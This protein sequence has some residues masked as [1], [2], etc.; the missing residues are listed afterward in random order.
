MFGQRKLAAMVLL[1]GACTRISAS[2]P[3]ALA[4]RGGTSSSGAAGDSQLGGAA[5]APE[6]RGG[7]AGESSLGGVSVSSFGG[8]S[9]SSGG[10]DSG[11]G[12]GGETAAAICGEPT[13][14]VCMRP[15]FPAGVV[16]YVGD[17]AWPA[18]VWSAV[19][20]AVRQWDGLPIAS[21]TLRF[22]EDRAANNRS[23][24]FELRPG[25]G[26]A[27]LTDEALIVAID[28]CVDEYALARAI[29]TALGLPRMHQRA[30]RGRYV[31][32]GMKEAFQCE[33][34]E[35]LEQCPDLG[36]IP[37]QLGGPFDFST[38]MFAPG[39][40]RECLPETVLYRPTEPFENL[41]DACLWLNDRF[42]AYIRE[43]DALAELY[44]IEHGFRPFLPIGGD[45]AP[46]APL[47]VQLA[48]GVTP[49]D[50][51]LVK[52]DGGELGVFVWATTPTGSGEIWFSRQSERGWYAFSDRAVTWARLFE[53]TWAPLGGA[54][55]PGGPSWADL[56][57]Y[58]GAQ[59]MRV[60]SVTLS[61]STVDV[62]WRSIAPP[63][64]DPNFVLSRVVPTHRGTS[65]LY[66]MRPAI[67]RLYV[68]E[69]GADGPI[70]AWSSLDLPLGFWLAAV[71][72]NGARHLVGVSSESLSY[73]VTNTLGAWSSWS[74]IPLPSSMVNL[75][76][77][78]VK[79]ELVGTP[80]NGVALIWLTYTG[81]LWYWACAEAPC[82][83]PVA[84]GEPLLLSVAGVSDI[85][86]SALGGPGGID[87]VQAKEEER[88]MSQPVRG[89]W[90]KH[91]EPMQ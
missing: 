68:Q 52:L 31:H 81:R 33:L 15:P 48:E 9:V 63:N 11:A 90:H 42:S 35:V 56:I 19:R 29:G 30:D 21:T 69:I 62:S 37:A 23:M 34:G 45:V 13:A 6:A 67:S 87:I 1:A 76:D 57:F 72:S 28:G 61:E 78:S 82:S 88:L 38:L 46:D 26:P 16:P 32:M 73:A 41:Y 51:T 3:A 85:P 40:P 65:L 14:Q 74:E 18:W 49:R 7:D 84:W 10:V 55:R 58:D 8:A 54:A 60:A 44:T 27:E 36:D 77:P 4:E 75:D 83:S 22:T 80:G 17:A 89:V 59:G 79:N 24:V 53:A 25:C 91:W 12:A 43:Q 39:A 47:D 86:F 70:S 5:A 50:Y 66:G 64:D 71:T 2:E 20:Q